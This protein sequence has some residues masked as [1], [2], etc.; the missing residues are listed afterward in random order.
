M[1]LPVSSEVSLEFTPRFFGSATCF[2]GLRRARESSGLVEGLSPDPS[3]FGNEFEAWFVFSGAW[4]WVRGF[5]I[6]PSGLVWR[7]KAQ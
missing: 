1:F 5:W 3:G 6:G 4:S 2:L 7:L